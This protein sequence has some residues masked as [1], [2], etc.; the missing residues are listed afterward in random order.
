MANPY[1]SPSKPPQDAVPAPAWYLVFA[2][3]SWPAWFIG[4]TLIVLRWLHLVTPT[5]G[6]IGFAIAGLA[7]LGSYVFPSLAGAKQEDVVVLDSRLLASQDGAYRTVMERFRNGASLLYDGVAFGFR[8]DNEIACAIV[9]SSPELDDG[10]AR[11]TANHAESVFATL[12]S[13]S[14]EFASAVADRT[15]R[16]SI[17]SGFDD[18]AVE[19]C[20]VVNRE[21]QWQR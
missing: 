15:F 12:K 7:A 21:L 10:S 4:T 8:P 18:D 9:A 20:R 13:A 5:V 6:W 11:E 16:I 2:R 17:M 19:I 14:P 1:Q 3:L